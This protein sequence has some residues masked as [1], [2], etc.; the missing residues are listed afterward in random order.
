[1][2]NQIA[3][4]NAILAATFVGLVAAAISIPETLVVWL[5]LA[6]GV[7]IVWSWL[8]ARATIGAP[9]GPYL[10]SDHGAV[11]GDVHGNGSAWYSGGGSVSG[12]DG[13]GGDGGGGD[14]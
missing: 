5:A 13:G 12:S 9:P 10:S 6:V 8:A 11:P 4:R 14:G 3:M 7:V 2:G 1:M